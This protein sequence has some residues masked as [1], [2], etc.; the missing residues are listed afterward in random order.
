MLAAVSCISECVVVEQ[1][2]FRIFAKDSAYDS[3]KQKINCHRSPLRCTNTVQSVITYL[4]E[5]IAS[6]S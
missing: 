3:I 4:C 6:S 2:Q 5:V 1:K